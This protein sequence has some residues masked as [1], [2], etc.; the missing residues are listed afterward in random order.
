MK[1]KIAKHAAENG[2]IAALRK[3]C[4]CYPELKES[5]I[6]TWKNTYITELKRKKASK[7]KDMEIKELPS[8]KRGRPFLLGAELDEQVKQYLAHVRGA[9]GIVNTAIILGVAEGIVK[10]V[11]SNLLAINGGHIVLTKSWAKSLL[12]RMGFVKRRGTMTAKIDVKNF[13][14]VKRQFLFDIHSIAAMEE[15][16]SDLI[17]N[18][19]QTSIHY[20][21]ISQWTMEKQ[22]S[23]H[24]EITAA[25]DKRQIMAVLAGSLAGDFLPPQLIYKGMT[26]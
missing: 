8:K 1:L 19:D 6:Q 4:C 22:G 25:D 13:E 21:P 2:V 3:H 12:S 24:V 26:L 11:D 5:T 7:Y 18:W 23:K 15:V 17:I 16:P 9:G 14:E 10:N 20:I